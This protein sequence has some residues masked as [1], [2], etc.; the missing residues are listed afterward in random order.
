MTATND[1]DPTPEPEATGTRRGG[2]MAAGTDPRKRRQILDGAVAVFKRQ[3]FDAASMADVASEAGVSKATLYVYFPSKEELFA[4]VI[5]EERDRNIANFL[6]MLDPS[7]PAPEV[8]TALGH[9][10]AHKLSQPHVVQAH[11]IVIGVCERMPEVGK[12]MF[13]AGPRRVCRALR[14]Y[15]EARVAAKELVIDDPELAAQQ[16]L[17]LCQAA[18]ARPRLYAF[19]DGAITDAEADRVVSSAVAMFLARY[20]A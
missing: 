1:D 12:Q 17:E 8:L 11:R 6:E 15:L 3:G 9:T 19:I 10:I 13:E 20:G 16:F 14:G 18:I 4:A 5:G 2:R 7:R